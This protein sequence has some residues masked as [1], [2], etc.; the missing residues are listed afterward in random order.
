MLNNRNKIKATF[1]K[2]I[3][4]DSGVCIA[5]GSESDNI[6]NFF[7]QF[8]TYDYVVPPI[9]RVGQVSNNGF[10]NEISYEREG[11]RANTILKSTAEQRSDNLLYEY[12]VG[13]Y[14]NKLN[15]VYSCFLETY[16]LF[17]YNK[18]SDW[19]YVK[20]N[21]ILNTN[22]F[23][24]NMTYIQEPNVSQGCT[25]A[26][27]L[28]IL[29]QHIR[30]AKTLSQMMKDPSKS[31]FRFDLLYVLY[32]IYM[33]LSNVAETFTHYDLH[34]NNI[35]V[36]EPVK[37][38][39]IQY[40]YHP[41]HEEEFT[42]TS[43][44]SRYIAKMIDYG[45]SYFND[46]STNINSLKIYNNVCTVGECGYQ[47]CGKDYGFQF[48]SPEK[49]IGSRSF[50][51]SQQPNISHDLRLLYIIKGSNYPLANE[52][53]IALKHLNFG[54]KSPYGTQE[55]TDFDSNQ[56]NNVHDAFE[57]LDQIIQM[58]H[59]KNINEKI[60]SQLQKIGDLH[61]YEDGR[62]MEFTKT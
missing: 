44:K 19:E 21:T 42:V 37:G 4:S 22:I 29:L 35:L 51:T 48:L 60:Y 34:T 38:K 5:F 57:V 30:N 45:R 26:K 12:Y 33:P 59:W 61:I 40:Y 13:Q 7:N 17:K 27:Y 6:K 8:I 46:P 62:P 11:Y 50:I 3:C 15:K 52:L 28:A 54:S 43:F 41:I 25:D 58:D 23:K 53:G 18:E 14:V 39:Y 31:S 32:Q 10:V 24:D 1:L 16:G 55:Q 49:Q 56:I 2:T 47:D 36:Y 20:N 9:Q